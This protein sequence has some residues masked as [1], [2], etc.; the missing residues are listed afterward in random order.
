MPGIV[1]RTLLIKLILNAS[2]GGYILR[3]ANIGDT[4]ASR[5]KGGDRRSRHI[6]NVINII[7]ISLEKKK[8]SRVKR[9]SSLYTSGIRGFVL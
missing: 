6:I 4:E 9:G 7:V 1:I 3:I 2:V 8:R 5:S